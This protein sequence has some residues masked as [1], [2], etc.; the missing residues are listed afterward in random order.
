MTRVEILYL[1]PY[2]FSLF[3]SLGITIYVWEHR[4]VQGASAY[5]IVTSAQTLIVLGFILELL[6]PDLSS[7][8]LWDKIQWVFFALASISI[9]YF[10]FQ[11]TNY[12]LPHPKLL[13]GLA[14]II[15]ALLVFGILTD[16]LTHLVYSNPALNETFIFGELQ[17]HFTWFVDL[18]A[19]Y[20][21]ITSLF[22]FIV[23][24][25]R[26]VHPHRLYRAQVTSVI[27][28]LLIPI[29]GTMLSV[30]QIQ[31]TPLRDTTPITSAIGNLI[32]AWSIFRYHWLDIVHIARDKVFENM[33]DLVIVL[34][35]QDRIV[36][37][38]QSALDLLNLKPNQVIGL[39]ADPIFFEWPE[40][41][42]KFDKPADANLEVIVKRFDQYRHFD[43]KSTLLYTRSGIYQGRIFVARDI[44]SYAALQRDLRELN[45][46]LERRVQVRTEELADANDTTLEGWANALELRDK[47]TEGHSRRV[48]SMTLLLAKELNFPEEELIHIRRGAI[49]HDIGKMAI[50]DEILRKPG[51]LTATER[52]VVSRHPMIAYQ[53][54]SRITFLRE[55][56]DIPYC[57]HE[58]WDG[59]GY[60]RGLKG[61]EIPLAAR[62]FSVVDVWDAVQSE[63]PYN[64][65]WSRQQAIQYLHEQAG[66]QFDPSIVDVFLRMVDQ[67]RI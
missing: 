12:K 30:L 16:P 33:N 51:K 25:R 17:Y 36:D 55:A 18:F 26:V 38:N 19:I 21:Y 66:R 53:L 45:E 1:L 46:D 49:L 47:E 29:L 4:T 67:D 43:I 60:P 39:P 11:Y 28:G 2:L 15:P 14:G 22:S 3:L 61:E 8:I 37:M 58:L 27:I 50:S 48:T 65:S 7:K 6:S 42:E 54:L 64:K 63:R 59:S 23:L 34:D 31:I 5:A 52:E 20:S 10:A 24:A 35:A 44:T 41:L 9:P 40:L 32:I 13:L 57:H 56:L 62:L